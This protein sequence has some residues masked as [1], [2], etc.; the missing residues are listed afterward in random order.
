MFVYSA[1]NGNLS[2][3]YGYAIFIDGSGKARMTADGA[4]SAV[5]LLTGNTSVNDGNWHYIAGTYD[6]SFVRLYV[7]GKPDATP[8]TYA[9][10]VLQ[11]DADTANYIG[12]GPS[13]YFSGSID[14][15]VIYDYARSQAQISWDFNRGLPI[16]HYKFDECSGATAND[17]S[18]NGYSGTLTPGASG[19]TSTGSCNSGTSTEMWNDGTTGKFNA[20]AG[21]DGTD[22]YVVISDTA[23]LRFDTSTQD[24][25]LSAW[26]KRTTTGTEYIISKE[27]ADNDG[28]RMQ[29]NS[30]NQ[31]VCSEDAT[32][33]TSTSTIT[34][35]NWHFVGCTID[36]DGNG[37]IYIDGI[38]NGSA[39]AMG[40]DAMATTS[41]IRIGTRS[42]TSTNYLNG[43]IDD[44]RIYNY[45]LTGA[46]IKN[47]MNEGSAVR[48]GPSSGQP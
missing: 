22:D 38:A 26:V 15:V 13:Y 31:I 11:Y 8:N 36:R 46:Q 4:S 27:D 45:A 39:V 44:V 42:Y 14:H 23:N 37:Q 5:S 21:F 2:S 25:S 10:G 48:F 24:F 9:G 3:I 29:F 17:A 40:T 35:T 34:D 20:S 18:G 28:W 19:N 47:V 6:G 1:N 30:S 16:A 43:L 7:D 12:Q 33:V 32:D 41:N